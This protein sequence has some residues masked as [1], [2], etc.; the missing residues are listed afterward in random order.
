MTQMS[1]RQQGPAP[2]QPVA[3]APSADLDS[4]SSSDLVRHIQTLT[5]A[6]FAQPMAN[7]AKQMQGVLFRMNQLGEAVAF[8]G[9]TNPD[10][11]HLNAAFELMQRVPGTQFE[12]AMK[13]V[14]G[15]A[16]AEQNTT[17][18]KK[19]K[20]QE[21]HHEK[22]KRKAKGQGRR[23]DNRPKRPKEA[24]S[25]PEAMEQLEKEGFFGGQK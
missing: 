13:A 1:Q 25:V 20:Q 11:Q 5:Q 3:P 23:P 7:T 2:A 8:L 9:K 18:Q 22:R 15:L 19:Q 24:K 21:K 10:F 6:Q 4:M 12:Y 17:L 14:K 16:M